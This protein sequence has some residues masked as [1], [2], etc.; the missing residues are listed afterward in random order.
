MQGFIKISR[1]N[2]IKTARPG[3]RRSP[4][5]AFVLR[6]FRAAG[7]DAADDPRRRPARRQGEPRKGQDDPFREPRR[8]ICQQDVVFPM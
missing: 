1:G 2:F 6:R 7:A 4:L 3:A 8:L 5:F